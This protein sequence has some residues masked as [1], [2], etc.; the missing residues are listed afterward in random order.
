MSVKLKKKVDSKER[1]IKPINPH[2]Q[3]LMIREGIHPNY[4]ILPNF[5]KTKEEKLEVQKMRLMLGRGF[6]NQK[7][8]SHSKPYIPIYGKL[9]IY[10]YKEPTKS[11]Y[12]NQADIPEILIK[13]KRDPNRKIIKYS[14]LGK[15]Y[16]PNEI[17]FWGK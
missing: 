1:K 14:W 9:I 12:C 10:A 6:Y 5:N 3:E 2:D 13:I 8:S 15:T 11:I 16:Q 7:W 17:P 4:L